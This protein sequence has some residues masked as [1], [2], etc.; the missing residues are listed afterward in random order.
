MGSL[1][2]DI[3]VSASADEAWAAVRDVGA[4]HTRL[5]PGFVVAT[6]LVTGGR[7]VT[8]AGGT[9]LREPIVTIDDEARRLVW[10]ADGGTTTHYNAAIQVF[11]EPGG[12]G[13]LV[14]IV[15][16]LPDTRRE[17]LD[18]AMGAAASAM[19]AALDTGAARGLEPR[20]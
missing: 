3:L 14:W 6:E 10:S 20:T 1:R 12:G 8:F 13:R 7:I 17:A 5:V 9:R 16:F 11:D 18:A 19:A 15:D 4:L 2:R